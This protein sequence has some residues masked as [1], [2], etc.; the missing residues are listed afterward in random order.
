MRYGLP[1]LLWVWV[2]C[3]PQAYDPQAVQAPSPNA[4]KILAIPLDKLAVPY[5]PECEMSFERFPIADTLTY[6]GKLYG[7]CSEGC[8]KAFQEKQPPK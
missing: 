6:E 1:L 3:Q 7:F 5:C 8:K 2:S 4:G